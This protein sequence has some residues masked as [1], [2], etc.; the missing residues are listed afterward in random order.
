MPTAVAAPAPARPQCPHRRRKHDSLLR[1]RPTA[2]QPRQFDPLSILRRNPADL[3]SVP[4]LQDY[5][6]DEADG[7]DAVHRP[8]RDPANLDPS[9]QFDFVCRAGI[10]GSCGMLIDGRPGWPAAPSPATSAPP[11]PWRRCRSSS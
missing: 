11:S 3:A 1:R 9:L 8:Q 5:E 4:H 10:C 6:L 2:G 7:S